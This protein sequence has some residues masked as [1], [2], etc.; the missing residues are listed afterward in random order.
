MVA[1]KS[2]RKDLNQVAA[3]VVRQATGGNRSAEPEK[4]TR[5]PGAGVKAD[6]GASPLERK[7]VRIDPETE[8]ILSLVGDGNLSLGIRE[9]ARRLVEAKDA[10]KFSLARH[11]KRSK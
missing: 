9:A 11:K 10:G 4:K 2:K 3:S 8:R 6:D 1:P 7:Q 5:A